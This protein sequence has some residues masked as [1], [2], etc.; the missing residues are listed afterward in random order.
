M[1]REKAPAPHGR[2][3][4][5]IASGKGIYRERPFTLARTSLPAISPAFRLVVNRRGHTVPVVLRRAVV[6]I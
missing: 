1:K 6:L 3:G 5:R 4:R 2:R